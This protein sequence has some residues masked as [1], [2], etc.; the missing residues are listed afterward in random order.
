VQDLCSYT[1]SPR[2]VELPIKQIRA[3][4]ANKED[5][6]WCLR[7]VCAT[8]LGDATKQVVKQAKDGDEKSLEAAHK[9]WGYE[10]KVNATIG[11]FPKL[12]Q[13]HEYLESVL[14]ARNERVVDAFY[15][16]ALLG[17][18]EAWNHL[19]NLHALYL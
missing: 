9:A 19:H 13:E 11:C 6:L 18:S 10:L 15:R 14:V 1:D 16:D 17:K 2:I 8:M 3:V 5:Y 12:P 7:C 4:V